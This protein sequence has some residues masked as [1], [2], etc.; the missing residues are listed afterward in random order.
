[1]KKVMIVQGR[2]LKTAYR[3]AAI[4]GAMALASFPSFAAEGGGG[5]NVPDGS[6]AASTITSG[7]AAVGAVAAAVLGVLAAIKVA[8]LIRRAL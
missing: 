3:N 5:G 8:K 4:G 6:A 1:M 2:R 7:M